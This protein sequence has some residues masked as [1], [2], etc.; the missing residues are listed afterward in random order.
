MEDR[1]LEK[2]FHFGKIA[3][4]GSR[5]ARANVILELRN[6]EKGL[7]LSIWGEICSPRGRMLCGGQC[8]DELKVYLHGNPTFMRLY[9]LWKDWQLHD[10]RAGTARQMAALEAK[11]IRSFDEACK[12][13]R[14]IGLETDSLADDERLSCETKDATRSCYRYGHGWIHRLLPEKVVDE[15]FSLCGE[16]RVSA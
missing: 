4:N 7:V 15:I 5:N 2:V 9:S 10:L 14:S 3:Y 1:V 11:G 6:S 12:Y 16:K 13:L 8:L